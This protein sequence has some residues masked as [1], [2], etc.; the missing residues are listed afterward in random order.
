MNPNRPELT[1]GGDSSTRTN[2]W[3]RLKRTIKRGATALSNLSQKAQAQQKPAAPPPTVAFTGENRVAQPHYDT[4]VV[5]L[6]GANNIPQKTPE[7]I[8]PEFRPDEPTLTEFGGDVPRLSGKGGIP[9]Y[10]KHTHDRRFQQASLRLRVEGKWD[11]VPWE[12]FFRTFHWWGWDEG[13]DEIVESISE[14]WD[15]VKD[16]YDDSTRRLHQTL[17]RIQSQDETLLA[18]AGD[19]GLWAQSEGENESGTNI[20]DLWQ[21]DVN[22]MIAF[23]LG[24]LN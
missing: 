16:L 10:I 18:Y 22:S 20:N 24:T 23:N 4:P 6:T 21:I 1:G 17:D 11:F 3:N 14:W 12:S 7:P 15:E 19:G 13:D 5:S 9:R 2:F 8:A